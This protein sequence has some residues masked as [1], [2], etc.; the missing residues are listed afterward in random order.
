MIGG[1]RNDFNDSDLKLLNVIA[2]NL[3]LNGIGNGTKLK[4][5]N[6]LYGQSITLY[7]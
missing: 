7:R 4:L 2:E 3:F 5:L 1:E 6:N